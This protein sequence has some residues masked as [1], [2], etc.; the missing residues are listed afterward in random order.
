MT[1]VRRSSP[2]RSVA[3][4][5]RGT[6]VASVEIAV[7]AERVYRALTTPE[8]L[9]RWWGGEQPYRTTGWEHELRVGGCWRANGQNAD[10]SSFAVTGEYLELDPPRSL[11][12]TWKPDWDPGAVTRVSY[13]LE[14]FDGGTRL[15]VH[16]EGFTNQDSCNNH[17]HGWMLVLNWLADFV[18]AEP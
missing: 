13:K 16:H 17:A 2:A 18:H 6:I 3:D 8:E 1:G 12:Y 10:G 9:V 15:T 7:P 5:T 11:V 4:V 14:A